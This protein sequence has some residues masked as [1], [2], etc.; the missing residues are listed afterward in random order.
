MAVDPRTEVPLQD[1]TKRGVIS[2]K[3][4]I[5][6]PSPDVSHQVKIDWLIALGVAIVPQ[7]PQKPNASRTCRSHQHASH[8]LE[9]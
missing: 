6:P 7:K 3:T 9:V 5:E 2:T 8:D 1:S 4:A